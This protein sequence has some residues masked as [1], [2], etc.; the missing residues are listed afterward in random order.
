MR[1]FSRAITYAREAARLLR[2][3]P[4]L[5]WVAVGLGAWNALDAGAFTH[6]VYHGT[7]WGRAEARAREAPR[8]HQGLP[9]SAEG[10]RDEAAWSTAYARTR[11]QF[12][13]AA[14]RVPT[15]Q[16]KGAAALVWAVTL[17]RAGAEGDAGHPLSGLGHS[18]LAPIFNTLLP[19]VV[20]FLTC[21]G[22]LGI[23]RDAVVSGETRWRR[24]WRHGWRFLWRLLLFGVLAGNLLDFAAGLLSGASRAGNPAV[25]WQSLRLVMVAVLYL[26]MTMFVVVWEGCSLWRAVKTA[27]RMAWREP[28]TALTV[29]AGAGLAQ[30]LAYQWYLPA[31]SRFTEGAGPTPPSAVLTMVLA[32]AAIHAI[33]A[34]FCVAAFLWCRAAAASAGAGGPRAEAAARR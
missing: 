33:G 13:I 3:R 28:G 18:L 32:N 24:F 26:E 8:L 21:A 19:L 34:W 22:Y 11:V 29:V 25:G 10:E 7:A 23:V 6:L 4:W 27:Y 2:K 1:D 30:W 20:G 16:A 14:P 15:L 17:G 9:S 5:L 31:L 12:R